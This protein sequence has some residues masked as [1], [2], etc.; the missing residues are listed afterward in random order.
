MKKICVLI[1]IIF[2]SSIA[3]TQQDEML[4][5]KINGKN[6]ETLNDATPLIEELKKLQ[7]NEDH[8]VEA[9]FCVVYGDPNISAEDD[10]LDL[11]LF[12]S[13]IFIRN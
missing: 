3:F 8:E 11:I 10:Q 4:G 7:A 12:F 1:F 9:D 6:V 2:S 13:R 5:Y